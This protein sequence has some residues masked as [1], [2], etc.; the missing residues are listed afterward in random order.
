MRALFER[1]ASEQE[2]RT[3]QKPRGTQ[4]WPARV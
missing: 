3:P 4:A 2:T 1:K